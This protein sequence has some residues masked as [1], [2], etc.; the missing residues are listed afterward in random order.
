MQCQERGRCAGSE[1][2]KVSQGETIRTDGEKSRGCARARLRFC[3][4]RSASD[5]GG[6]AHR[7]RARKDE[8]ARRGARQPRTW[9]DVAL[10][11]ASSSA[12]RGGSA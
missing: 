9:S 2:S 3:G 10:H 12:L 5:V 7:D 8:T 11:A 4:N 1:K 6:P